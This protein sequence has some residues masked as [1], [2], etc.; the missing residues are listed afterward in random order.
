MS[1]QSPAR[2]LSDEQQAQVCGI[3]SV[4]CD[5]QTAADFIGCSL[6]DICQAMQQDSEF[7]A[8]VL[9]AEASAELSHMRNVQ[10]VAKDKKEWRA[11]VWWLESRSPERFARRSGAVTARQLKAFV[12][13]LVDTLS[14]EVTDA[15]DR[16][17]II[18]RLQAIGESVDQML[19]DAQINAADI[20]ATATESVDTAAG[21]VPENHFAAGLLG[22][23]D[24]D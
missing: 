7:L 2:K 8:S 18:V 5:R 12:K 11:S 23:H 15:D 13:I 16:R 17:R 9:R 22:S 14:S 3:L 21:N 1:C 10:A 4:G 6:A 20:A 19:R 24:K